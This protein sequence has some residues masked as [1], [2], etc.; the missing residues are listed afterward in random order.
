MFIHKKELLHPVVVTQP[1]AN[2]AQFLLEQFG[3]ATGELTAGL[4]YFVQSQ[5]PTTR[6]CA[7]CCSTS[8]PRN[9][10]TSKLS[11]T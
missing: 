11:L 3:G 4:Q 7:T 6:I 10:D 2:F 9:S 5:H 1:S 8:P